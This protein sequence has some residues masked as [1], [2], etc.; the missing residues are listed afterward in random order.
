MSATIAFVDREMRRG[1]I[2]GQ[3]ALRPPRH[4]VLPPLTTTATRAIRA[5]AGGPPKSRHLS[6]SLCGDHGHRQL[7]GVPLIGQL[8]RHRGKVKRNSS[9][10]NFGRYCDLAHSIAFTL[11]RYR[12]VVKMRQRGGVLS[13]SKSINACLER[14]SNIC[15]EAPLPRISKAP[16]R[17]RGF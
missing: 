10:P 7:D 12:W 2:Q 16:P 8:V 1:S 11:S 6:K 17:R 14:D 9:A 15:G 4:G 3:G 5:T 13:I